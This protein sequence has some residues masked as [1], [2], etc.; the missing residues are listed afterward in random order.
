MWITGGCELVWGGR[1]PGGLPGGGEDC[2]E[3]ERKNE[4]CGQ[5]GWHE[6]RIEG[7]GRSFCGCKMQ[8]EGEIARN[9]AG[10]VSRATPPPP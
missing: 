4:C 7:A 10:E 5:R 9:E 6:L 3:S 1:G 2:S 8:S